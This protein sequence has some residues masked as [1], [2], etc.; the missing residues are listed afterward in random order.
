VRYFLTDV[1]LESS[2][3]FVFKG[4]HCFFSISLI[5]ILDEGVGSLFL[6]RDVIKGEKEMSG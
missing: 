2:H 6:L 5:V 3:I 1:D 4:G